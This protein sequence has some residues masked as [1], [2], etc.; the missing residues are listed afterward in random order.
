MLL[1]ILVLPSNYHIP[2]KLYI[3]IQEAKETAL[4]AEAQASSHKHTLQLGLLSAST[5]SGSLKS[6]DNCI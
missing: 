3:T 4:L 5:W 1:G 6:T 2:Y